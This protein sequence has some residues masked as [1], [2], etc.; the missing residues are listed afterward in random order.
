MPT[1]PL[2]V[3]LL[4]YDGFQ[5]LDLVGPL[6]AFAAA[7][8]VRRGAYR[9]LVV[10]LD[11]EPLVSETGLTVTPDCALSG[12]WP[13]DTLILPGGAGLRR[14]GAAAPIAEA[15]RRA[16][17][18]LRR[19]VSV[20]TGLYGLAASGLADGRRA[21]TH[22]KFAADLAARF[23]ALRLEPD[24]IFIKD[25]PIYSS[26]GVT[27]AIDLALALIEE[28]HG[29]ALAMAT[30]RDLVVYLKR[31]GGQRQYSEPLR[32]QAKAGDRFADLAAWMTEHLAGDLGV[33][34]LADRV[35]LSPRQFNRRF[36]AHFGQSPARQVESL[37]LD[38]ARLRLTGSP[39]S[40][41]AIATAVGFRSADAFGR[42]FDRRFGLAPSD[43][44]RRFASTIGPPGDTHGPNR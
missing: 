18:R 40:I 12:A 13:L 41:E 29:P 43:Y 9:T 32:F 37:R 3:A 11:G 24:A 6:D 4:G 1:S 44:R 26:A 7:N 22:W 39:A 5:T 27:A 30:A 33:E 25:G 17:P 31:A 21:T 20:C 42:A 19:I 28:D 38:A 10:S 35:H 2:R 34:S 23:P 16:A 8:D 15:L 36:V 14:P